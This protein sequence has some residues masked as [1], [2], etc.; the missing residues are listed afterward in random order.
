MNREFSFHSS[1]GVHI[2]NFITE[3]QSM[4]YK[5]I[6]QSYLLQ[7]FDAYWAEQGYASVQ[8][9]PETL[10][11]WIKKRNRECKEY[12]FT[13]ISAV[14]EFSK[15]L[16]GLGIKSFIPPL[17]IRR[18][19]PLVH[20]LC[21]EEI[22]ELF[23]QIDNYAPEKQDP[24]NIMI[25]LEY[26]ILFRLIY[27]CGLRISEACGLTVEQVDL[28]E[29]ILTLI[30]AKGNKDRLI[31]LS[32]DMRRLCAE[33]FAALRRNYTGGLWFFPG[34]GL[35][36]HIAQGSVSRVFKRCWTRT[37]FA[38]T[39]DITPTVHSL[40]HTF[41]VKRVNLWMRQGLN[42]N[43]M[44]PYLSKYLG[45]KGVDETYY[46]YHYVEESARV[47]RER[48]SLGKKVIPEVRRR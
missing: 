38:E 11:G 29:G 26:P 5:Y 19:K 39:C 36:N 24:M 27:C 16:N 22:L 40:R 37:F 2:Q 25:S 1:L 10:D 9:T 13:R 33:Y 6:A 47:I 35:A 8:L 20:I 43:A 34:R 17:D 44:M 45:H 18:T 32:D 23:R 46:Y 14:R 31:Y 48:D 28:D 7:E 3:K 21:D 15:Y 41:V 42:M 12:Q 30:N 4:G